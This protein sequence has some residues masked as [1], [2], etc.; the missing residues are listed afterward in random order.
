MRKRTLC[1]ICAFSFLAFFCTAPLLA[2]EECERSG[3]ENG[4]YCKQCRWSWWYFQDT[5]QDVEHA[6]F[7]SCENSIEDC[8]WEEGSCDYSS[9][10][11]PGIPGGECP[12][13]PS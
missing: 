5:C 11:C 3:G 8:G 4:E 6:A 12:H 13:Q 7:C 2:E 10:D 1:A 9:E